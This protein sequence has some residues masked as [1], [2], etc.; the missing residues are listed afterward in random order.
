M[1]EF[2]S[3]SMRVF[4]MQAGA[5][6]YNARCSQFLG[7]TGCQP[8]VAGSLPATNVFGKLPKTAGW[9]PALPGLAGDIA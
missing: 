7:S 4:R 1:R 5:K 8:V 9:Q 6:N 2:F 3:A